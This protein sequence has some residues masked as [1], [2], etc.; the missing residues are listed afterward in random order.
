M[1]GDKGAH[2]IVSTTV[3]DDGKVMVRV[4]T[5]TENVEIWIAESIEWNTETLEYDTYGTLDY[6]QMVKE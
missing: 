2:S 5:G 3:G 1:T 4:D 6:F